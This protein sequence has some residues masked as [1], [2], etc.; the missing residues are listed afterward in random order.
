MM[1]REKILR[2]LSTD[3]LAR[4]PREFDLVISCGGFFGFYV[5]GLDR[6]LKKMERQGEARVRR[7]AGAS[8]G[9]IC[10]VLMC[11]GVSNMELV[12]MYE[13]LQGRRDYFVRLRDELLRLL[14]PDAYI[15]CTD[16]VFIHAARISWLG[17]RGES[18]SR[19]RDNQDLVD[20]CMASANCPFF[21]SPFLVYRYRG[22]WYLDGCFTRW[23]P[24]FHDSCHQLLVRLERVCYSWT[25]FFR[26]DDESI[27]GLVVKGAIEA[28]K[29]LHR[30][31]RVRALEW[32]E[33]YRPCRKRRA[34]RILLVILAAGFTSSA[35]CFRRKK[36]QLS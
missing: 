23:L 27:E 4:P 14:P 8:V 15:R 6:V 17:L 2:A 28:E 3:C 24:M 18:F 13:R 34:C 30:D 21:I 11:C 33:P 36:L 20:A 35:L 31:Q 12:E 5:V 1:M 22:R 29:F 10:S 26:P 7:Y 9:A 16:R 25:A 19:F 32:Y